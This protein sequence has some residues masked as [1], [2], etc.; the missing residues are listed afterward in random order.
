MT[1]SAAE[2]TKALTG[3]VTQVL[4]SLRGGPVRKMAPFCDKPN[5]DTHPSC[6]V[7]V[8]GGHNVF[9]SL[10]PVINPVL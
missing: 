5:S 4:L 6:K 2:Q 1:L 9:M 10:L 8:A 3:M 7:L